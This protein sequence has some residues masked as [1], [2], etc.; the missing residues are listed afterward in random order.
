M[1]REILQKLT[2][3]N[4]HYI[5]EDQSNRAFN[6]EYNKQ[7]INFLIETETTMEIEFLHK[8]KKWSEKP[9]NKYKITLKNKK[10]VYSFNFWDSIKNTETIKREIPVI[11]NF[12]NVL[13]CIKYEHFFDF[14]DFCQNFGYEFRSEKEYIKVKQIYLDV[15]DQNKTLQK[16][17]NEV[18][19]EKLNEIC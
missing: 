10:G 1:N 13:S 3:N 9:V 5:S 6:N 11:L 12:Y 2:G 19:L 8:E 15:M 18:E 7:A 16:M 4:K 14:D 17:F